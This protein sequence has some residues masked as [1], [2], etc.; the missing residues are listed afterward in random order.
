V[1]IDI[2]LTIIC[3]ATTIT[4]A[5]TSH[6]AQSRTHRI[7]FW[8]SLIAASFIILSS[9]AS[10]ISTNRKLVELEDASHPRRL[11]P[12]QKRAIISHLSKITEKE[13]ISIVAGI[14]DGEAMNFAKD[15]ESVFV[16]AGFEVEFFKELE[17]KAAMSVNQPGLHL[18][19]KD[20]KEPFPL[21]A[22]IQRIFMN[23]GIEIP[24][25]NSSNQDSVSC[26]ITILV[27]QR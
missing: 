10:S 24:G 20:I 9:G 26:R 21:A 4:L 8:T 2:I 22:K 25:L 11:P 14:L 23:V 7:L 5:F 18:L 3:L 16:S 15:I 13:R 12:K 17:G 19:V 6:K 27:G 1:L